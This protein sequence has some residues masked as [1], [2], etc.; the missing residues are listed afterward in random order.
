[1][2]R[3]FPGGRDTPSTAT[4]DAAGAPVSWYR[5]DF[6]KLMGASLALAGGGCARSPLEPIVPF[7]SG[8]AE[9]TYGKPVY[10]AT[11]IARTGYAAGVLVET[12]MG[13]PTKI[14]GNPLH[15]ASL[16]ATDIL[17]QAAVLE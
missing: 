3:S 16:G 9:T 4:P 1:M 2:K 17:T 10:F 6:M 5:R 13:R 12:N 14:E 8:P 7:H 15:P 11:A